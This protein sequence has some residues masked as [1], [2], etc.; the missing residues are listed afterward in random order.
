M[1]RD[2]HTA[3]E[4]QVEVRLRN[5]RGCNLEKMEEIYEWRES[6]LGW[7]GEVRERSGKSWG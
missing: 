1:G 3:C 5:W 7:I 6:S 2:E 4:H